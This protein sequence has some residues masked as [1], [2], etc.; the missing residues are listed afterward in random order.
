VLSDNYIYFYTSFI[1]LQKIFD[2]KNTFQ[3]ISF[4]TKEKLEISADSKAVFDSACLR[5]AEYINFRL[6]PNAT[7]SRNN[8]RQTW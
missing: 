2:I 5:K 6:F 8:Q 7:I 1:F 3:T 4:L